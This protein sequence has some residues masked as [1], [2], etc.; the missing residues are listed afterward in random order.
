MKNK[1]KLLAIFLATTTSSLADNEVF[2]G[3]DVSGRDFSGGSYKNS[4][5]VG[6]IGAKETFFADNSFTDY[7]YANFSNANHEDSNFWNALLE[8]VNF[9][10]ANLKNASFANGTNLSGADFSNATLTGT[11]FVGETGITALQLRTAKD[12]TGI[13]LICDLTGWDLSSFNM[14][15]ANFRNS[16]LKNTNFENSII[17]NANFS[18]TTGKGFTKEQLYSTLSYKEKKLNGLN[19][20]LNSMI[21]WDFSGQDLTGSEIT[22]SNITNAIF[23]NAILKNVKISRT[24]GLTNEQLNGAKD[25]RGMY[26]LRYDMSGWDLSNKDLT[27]TTFDA[28]VYGANKRGSLSGANFTNSNLCDV[29]FT[30]IDIEGAIFDNAVI[31]G[32]NF[33]FYSYLY[34]GTEG[35]E[36]GITKEQLYSTLS[37]KNGDLIKLSLEYINIS[38]WDLKKQNL[39]HANF[40]NTTLKD[41]DFSGTDLRGA[42]FDK[43]L[44]GT[45]IYKNTIMADGVIKNFSMVSANDSLSIRKYTSA[46]SD[47]TT[48]SAKIS[49]NDAVVSGEA[50]LSLEQGAE[51]IVTNQ[52]TLTIASD[53]MLCIDTD[54]EGYTKMTVDNEAG[55]TFEDGAK[56]IVNII[57]DVSV[58]EGIEC[59]ALSWYDGANIEGLDS[60]ETGKTLLLNINGATYTGDWKYEIKGNSLNILINVPEPSTYAMIFGA[61]AIGFAAYRR[62]K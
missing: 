26:F 32:A 1:I 38:D 47:E 33:S 18:W 23:D 43:T 40:L 57:G 9:S 15:G 34:I 42:S 11:S 14:N 41:T 54:L 59:V 62:R 46:T 39:Q 37:Y 20:S 28:D 56:F 35:S 55:L 12:I 4:S 19:L 22:E 31:R 3:Q 51:L 50:V 30:N 6:L 17:H 60:L 29:N 27:G 2:D 49:E 5:W 7:S 24:T 44:N 16:T 45:P 58:Q 52:K 25:I 21:G 13:E 61:I 48:V 10:N 53:G 8:N 36:S